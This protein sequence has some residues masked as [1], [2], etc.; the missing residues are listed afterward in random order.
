MVYAIVNA[1]NEPSSR[2]IQE[3]Q[4]LAGGQVLV[5]RIETNRSE[6]VVVLEQYGVEV[7]RAVG[8]GGAPAGGPGIPA[9]MMP[10]SSIPAT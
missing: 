6:P 1:P 3:G 8:E 4:R 5:K 2:Y 7:V 10:T 9:A